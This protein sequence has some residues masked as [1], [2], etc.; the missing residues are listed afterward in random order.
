M[1]LARS[2][3]EAD[4]AIEKQWRVTLQVREGGRERRG[5]REEG[6]E[7]GGEGGRGE[8]GGERKEG[9]RERIRVRRE[10]LEERERRGKKGNC[11]GK[12]KHF[13]FL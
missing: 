7:G 12:L 11:T 8:E 9:G 5:G 3:A 6:R 2:S 4:L 13:L 10:V 1:Q